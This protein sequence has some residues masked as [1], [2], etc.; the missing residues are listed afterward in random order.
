MFNPLHVFIIIITKETKLKELL[1]VKRAPANIEKIVVCIP[2]DIEVS[3]E[4]RT[5]LSK[6][7]KFIPTPTKID[8]NEL[9]YPLKFFYRRLKLHAHFNDPNKSFIDDRHVDEE[10]FKKYSKRQ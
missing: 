7:L 8:E 9:N 6:G 2:D 3:R 5:V 4:E 1:P 10:P